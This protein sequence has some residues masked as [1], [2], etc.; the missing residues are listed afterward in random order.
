M[1]HLFSEGQ[2]ILE[3]T[4]EGSLRGS[5]SPNWLRH[6]QGPCRAGDQVGPPLLP[7]SVSGG[8]RDQPSSSLARGSHWKLVPAS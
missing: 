1:V 4:G 6:M 7:G 2:N 5:C 8:C 3:H